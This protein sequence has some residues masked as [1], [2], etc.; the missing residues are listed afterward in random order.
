[1]H[2][3]LADNNGSSE[4]L[5]EPFSWELLQQRGVD[6]IFMATLF[7]QLQEDSLTNLKERLEGAH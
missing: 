3:Q 2:P 5:V 7:N 1:M 4:L 6:L